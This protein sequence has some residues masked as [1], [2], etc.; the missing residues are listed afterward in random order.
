MVPSIVVNIPMGLKD[1]FTK[2]FPTAKF[3][4]RASLNSKNYSYYLTVE[5][6]EQNKE[7]IKELGGNKSRHQPFIKG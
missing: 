2:A 6:Y 4:G 3:F 7:R 1:L 5:E